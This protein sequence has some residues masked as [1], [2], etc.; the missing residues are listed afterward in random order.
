MLAKCIVFMHITAELIAHCLTCLLFTLLNCIRKIVLACRYAG[1]SGLALQSSN[2]NCP[3][4]IS[5]RNL[6]HVLDAVCCRYTR[7]YGDPVVS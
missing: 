2:F 5:H 4:L 3:E 7:W 6:G 1:L